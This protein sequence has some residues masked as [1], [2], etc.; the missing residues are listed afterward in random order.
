MAGCESCVN[1]SC[2]TQRTGI[3]A[4]N[5][6]DMHLAEGDT[7][8]ILIEGKEQL[9]GALWV[10]GMPLALFIVGYLAGRALFPDSGEGPAVGM[11][12]AS[13]ALGMVAGIFVQKGRKLDSLPKVVRKI[14]ISEFEHGGSETGDMPEGSTCM[15]GIS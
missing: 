3:K 8:E 6:D 11:S 12:V 2:K 15:T 1:S 7:I 4:Y 13:L 5:R 14:D 10:L 9:S